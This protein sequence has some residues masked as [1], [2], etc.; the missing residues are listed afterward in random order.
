M[1]V[2]H[3][4]SGRCPIGA[5]V[6][7]AVVALS[8][9]GPSLAQEDQDK[10]SRADKPSAATNLDKVT[11]TGSRIKRVDIEGPSPVTVITAD[12]IQKEGFSTVYEALSTLSQFTGS[13][14]N[15]INQSGFT[16]N[17]QFINLRSLGPGYQL[18]LLNG[19]RLADYPMPYNSQ[20][21]AVSLSSIPAAAVERIEVM[22]GGASAIYGSDAVAGVGNIITK[23]NFD[24]DSLYV[25]GG[26]TTRGGGDTGLFQWTGGKT[27]DRWNLIY[28]LEYFNRES[29]LASQRD[30]MDSYHD[31]PRYRNDPHNATAVSGVY[32]YRNGPGYVWPD[33]SGKLSDSVE[34]LRSACAATSS[35][36][37]PYRS[38]RNVTDENRCGYFGYPATQSIQNSFDKA[39]AYLSGTFDFGQDTQAYGQLLYTHS[40][41]TGASATRFWQTAGWVHDPDI[42]YVQAQRIFTPSETGGSQ[43][44]V[45][46]EETLSLHL[47]LRGSWL[48][49]RF[50][51]EGSMSHARYDMSIK[52]PYFTTD[53]VNDYFFGDL[54]GH[55]GTNKYPSYHVRVDRLFSP[56]STADY[57]SLITTV[58]STAESQSSQGQFTLTGDL[59]DL[60]AGPVGM[61]LVVEGARQKYSLAPDVRSTPDYA[62]KDSIYDLTSTRGGGSRDRY[63]LG[64]EFS[65]PLL[66]N[67]KANLAGRYDRYDDQTDVDGAFTWQAG[68]EW[69]PL[70]AL[71]LRGT[72][73]TSFRA[74][75]MH[76][77]YAGHSGG[78][79]YITDAYLCRVKGIDPASPDCSGADYNYQVFRTYEGRKD[80]RE[81]EGR[82]STAGV[83]WDV[84]KQM[85]V[86]LDYYSI[87]LENQVGEIH[88][89]YLMR[90]YADCRLGTDTRGNPV[91]TTSPS[92]LHFLGLITR[93][94]SSLGNGKVTRYAAYPVNQ[95]MTRSEGFDATWKYALDTD[96]WGKFNFQINYTHV[97]KLDLQRFADDEV[98]NIRDHR[99]YFN[100]RSRAN[101]LVGWEK[102]DWRTNL[103]G[104]RYGSLPSWD[105]THRIAPYFLWNLDVQKKITPKATIGF[106]AV[107]VFNKLHPRD[108]SFTSYPFFWR[109]YSPV[110][111]QVFANYRVTF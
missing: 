28:A 102:N 59:F 94:T 20:S 53:K 95:A 70:S 101:W 44:S 55:V 65:A 100:Y 45:F 29:I 106:S 98:E 57:Q 77:V 68:L 3:A 99:R 62:G 32:L 85:S 14:Q 50:D 37:Q 11:V 90:N 10:E 7:F 12:D 22:T 71:L 83:V 67:L 63:A 2:H 76:Y 103:Y 69:R 61:A 21:N 92:C 87:K 19:K 52:T 5:A 30:F 46:E 39:S 64:V 41:N 79:T 84:M 74:P 6:V 18:V 54:L 58:H 27:G 43:K 89:D 60:P 49:G 75:D 111:R 96:R 16:P 66:H 97:T 4:V 42:G 13:V 108:D 88:S 80:L 15:E 26:T 73:A 56:L 25:R 78:Y 81:E 33:A 47:G 36:F 110:G 86:S 9:H 104:Y 72:H 109:S 93:D 8:F 24:G 105:E 82:S 17:A 51:W 38:A 48:G 1:Q 23:S 40:K 107:N 35:D 31:N 91:D 34:A